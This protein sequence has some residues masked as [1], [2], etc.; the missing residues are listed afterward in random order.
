MIFILQSNQILELQG[1]LNNKTDETKHL[2]ETADALKKTH[3]DQNERIEV[4][5]KKIQEVWY[6]FGNFIQKEFGN[7]TT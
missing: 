7:R 1:Q 6:S 3:D 2:Q 4:L 5:V